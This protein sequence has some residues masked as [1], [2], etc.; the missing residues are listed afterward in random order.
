MKQSDAEKIK[1]Y[2][3]ENLDEIK[4]RYGYTDDI[5]SFNKEQLI[6]TIIALYK[7]LKRAS[8]TNDEALD[9][10]T[11][12]KTHLDSMS[13][14][15]MDIRCSTSKNSNEEKL[16]IKDINLFTMICEYYDISTD[17]NHITKHSLFKALREIYDIDIQKDKDKERLQNF[18]GIFTVRDWDSFEKI[19]EYYGLIGINN[20]NSQSLFYAIKDIY[21]Q[22]THKKKADEI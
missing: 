7:D 1:L 3:D 16:N 20:M 11:S 6:S 15:I 14:D 13:Y 4:E 12:I 17:F 22:D 21:Y 5:R 8:D 18:D 2:A 19:K 9:L 10:L